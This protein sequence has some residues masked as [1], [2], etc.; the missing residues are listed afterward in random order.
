MN[1]SQPLDA[2]S[3]TLESKPRHSQI[4]HLRHQF[5][6]EEQNGS[7]GGS[8]VNRL[9]RVF[10]TTHLDKPKP[11]LPSKPPSLRPVPKP[12]LESEIDSTPLAFKD[13]RARFQQENALPIKQ[14]KKKK[15]RLQMLN[16]SES[17]M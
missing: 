15:K 17:L 8:S 9:S 14:V 1:R 7:S 13:I 2:F 10:E 4:G 16:V 3:K 12:T 11:A 5:Q 6:E